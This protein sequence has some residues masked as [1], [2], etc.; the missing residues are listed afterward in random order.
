MDTFSL[1]ERQPA[2]KRI[3]AWVDTDYGDEDE[4]TLFAEGVYEFADLDVSADADEEVTFEDMF[5]DL[6]DY[7]ADA[8]LSPDPIAKLIREK[9][10]VSDRVIPRV[11][12]N[13]TRL[14][15]PR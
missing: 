4:R 10:L 5:D 13:L 1:D 6:S 8:D 7:L 3:S 12:S 2:I 11:A 14:L 15:Q 9:Q